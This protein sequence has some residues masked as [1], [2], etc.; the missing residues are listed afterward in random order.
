MSNFLWCNKQQHAG[1]HKAPRQPKLSIASAMR[2]LSG[3]WEQLEERT[4][5]A[6]SAVRIT[7]LNPGAGDSNPSV[8]TNLN[9]TYYFAATDVTHGTELWKTDGTVAGTTLVK[10]IT[11]GTGS[12]NIDQLSVVKDKLFFRVGSDLWKSDGT[13]AGT[14]IIPIADSTNTKL[15]V[16]KLFALDTRLLF[17]V[18]TVPNQHV[19]TNFWR[20]DGTASGTAPVLVGATG[21]PFQLDDYQ[22]LIVANGAIYIGYDDYSFDRSDAVWK[23]DGTNAG[24]FL[25]KTLQPKPAD[26]FTYDYD[27][28]FTA[29][30]GNVFF[31]SGGRL[32]K[33][34]GTTAG[35]VELHDPGE[36]GAFGL[37]SHENALYFSHTFYTSYTFPEF[38]DDPFISSSTSAIYRSNVNTGDT[39]RLP[40]TATSSS[41]VSYYD[42]SAGNTSSNLPVKVF[43]NK[44][45][46]INAGH[47]YPDGASY[48]S[49]VTYDLTTQKAVKSK[50]F[51]FGPRPANFVEWNGGLTYSGGGKI[52][53][54]DGTQTKQLFNGH[55]NW[56]VSANDNLFFASDIGGTGTELWK[57]TTAPLVPTTTVELNAKGEVEIRDLVGKAD[58]FAISRVGANLVVVDKAAV[59]NTVFAVSNVT[60]AVLSADGGT[61]VIP[62]T[63][64]AATGQPLRIHTGTGDDTIEIDAQNKS[65]DTLISDKGWAIDFG[66]GQDQLIMRNA[67][68]TKRWQVTGNNTG[69][70]DLGSSILRTVLFS[71]VESLEGGAGTD[72]FV[73]GYASNSRMTLKGGDG[74]DTIQVARDAN[75]FL[76]DTQLL[77]THHDALKSKDIYPLSSI[78]RATL[79]G[80][81]GNDLLDARTFTG[82]LQ[83]FGL[84]G[85]DVLWGGIGNDF[86]HGGNGHDWLSGGAGND[87]L[88][89]GFGNDILVGGAGSD[90]LNDPFT[91][92]T[93]PGD[94]ILIGGS[95]TYDYH[96]GA[97]DAFIRNWNKPFDFSSRQNKLLSGL[98]DQQQF[99]FS[100]SNIQD[101]NTIDDLFG[102][103]G[104]DWILAG[105]NDRRD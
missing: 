98:G 55:A 30:G 99:N 41:S 19:H 25:L 48:Y 52:W 77:L 84:A 75:A 13:E 40:D 34:N 91:T 80:G 103:A 35:T 81:A 15:H 42:Y 78:E 59:A 67:L 14:Q 58:A 88:W 3:G 36:G 21:Q 73:L 8:A 63:T 23:S 37:F 100:A 90:K 28:S 16:S 10:D 43:N 64:L 93:H 57:L 4:L 24:T 101:D 46:F 70:L 105:V 33:S 62:I 53:W 47:S 92:A 61:L 65:I 20:T 7:D 17:T 72:S 49:V 104:N 89:G 96:R 79:S 54:S 39:I 22:S 18:G 27:F 51:D 32:W 11:P 76:M 60:G 38:P 87:T 82:N 102:G 29:A 97:I 12:S 6:I 74:I 50:A 69:K 31:Q 86:L 56:L 66:D 83:L 71:Q 9:G 44:L 85:N 2:W 94:D 95:T 1:Q 5:L 26:T 45:F 68:G